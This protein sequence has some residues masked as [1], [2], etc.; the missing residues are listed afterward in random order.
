MLNVI[1][2]SILAFV[3]FAIG[4]SF[5][6]YQ[7]TRAHSDTPGINVATCT[8][9]PPGMV[10]WWPGEGN[11]NDIRGENNGVFVGTQSY[12]TGEVEHAFSFD[13]SYVEIPDSPSLSITGAISIDAWINPTTTAPVDQEILSKYDSPATQQSYSLGV[14]TG[15]SLRFAI[16]QTGDASILRYVDTASGTVSAGTF[17][18]VAATFDPATQ[19]MK[20]YVNGTDTLVSLGAGS[21]TVSSI[22]DSTTPVRIGAVVNSGNG[23]DL[24]IGLIDE[25]E[26]FSRALTQPEIQN[27]VTAGPLGKCRPR[28]TPPAPGMVS[29]WDGDDNPFDRQGTNHGSMPPGGAGFGTGKVGRA[30]TFDGSQN[31][32]AIPDDATLDTQTLTIDAWVFPTALDGA[33]DII[34]N[35]EAGTVQYEM[36]IKG[37]ISSGGSIPPGHLAVYV[38]GL[39]L[40]NDDGGWVDG[41][42][43]VP[44][45]TWSHVA[46][47]FDGSTLNA[48]INGVQ[49]RQVTGLSG[50]VPSTAGPFRIG[51]RNPNVAFQTDPFN[52]SI[53][54]VEFFNRALLDTEIQ[55]INNA[56]FA[57]KCK[58]CLAP[59]NN[60][61]GWWAGDGDARDVS[62]AGNDGSVEGALSF[63]I[64]KVGQSFRFNGTDAAVVAAP[65]SAS[66]MNQL[67]LTV[68]AWVRPALREGDTVDDFFPNNAV[69]NDMPGS[70]GHGFGVNVMPD[71]SEMTVEYQDGF[72]VIPDVSFN[73]DQWYHIA[74]VYTDGNV[75]SY[76]DGL[77]VDDFSDFDQGALDST[78]PV[79]IGKH[80]DDAETYGTRRFFKGLIDEVEIFNRA[81]DQKELQSLVA[82]GAS[83]KCKLG[84]STQVTQPNGAPPNIVK[85]GDATITF[86][87]GAGPG[88]AIYQTLPTYQAGPMNF[89]VSSPLE[90]L[91]IST[92]VG[93]QG[94]THICF[95]LQADEFAAAPFTQL[96]VF[97][98]EGN[99][100]VNRTSSSSSATRT[101]CA[102]VASFS[103]F[104]IAPDTN[105][106]TAAPAVISGQVTSPDGTPLAGVTMNLS[107]ASS[108]HT[109]TDSDG[110]YHFNNVNVDNFYTVAPS[111]VN[112]HFN[113]DSRSFSLLANK[114][115]AVFTA[116]PD[117]VIV[118]N[119]IDT[120]DYFVRQHYLDFLG[121]EPDEAGFNFWSDQLASCGSDADC[122]EVKRINVSAAYFLSIEFQQTGGLVD[123]LYRTSYGR[124]PLY[125]EFV[126]DTSRLAQNVVVGMGDWEHQLAANKQTFVADW[127]ERT[128]FKHAFDSL[129]NDAYIEALIANTGIAFSQDERVELVNSLA[130]G[131]LTRAGALLRIAED[132]R[133]V[134]AKRNEAFVMMEYF[135]YLRRDPDE[136]GYQFWLT[137]LNQ[138]GGNFEQAE[139]VKAFINSG[140][141]RQRFGR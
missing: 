46:M 6:S 130:N 62:G 120:P 9:P 75:K 80:N 44:L 36:S 61:I 86:P 71:G 126:P 141:Y 42:G 111:R 38:G 8:P 123:G 59:P 100:L 28:C 39:N 32:V 104:V 13:G 134:S 53:D 98:Q 12:P 72:R 85:V 138:F 113:P 33:E 90:V 3:A 43:A 58:L 118:G 21:T 35:K 102:D 140:E 116:V 29:W 128:A 127:V 81:L 30:F 22:F 112:Y 25:V 132:G 68:D 129:G 78:A 23:L 133:F 95:N 139:M 124:R 24:F 41:G 19:A 105:A 63:A 56:G 76:V 73:A 92:T 82:A 94:T 55:K 45:N 87:F 99:L 115:D 4:A 83:G 135:G 74:I 125:A 11:S 10:A 84:G 18:H 93:L 31:P 37:S 69:S 88:N 7:H 16:Y 1:R 15:G 70:S 106:P 67:P 60:M 26:L 89:G 17:T 119:T 97:H 49:T 121:R 27:I 14:R 108:A 114:T 117:A 122:L 20:I 52:G 57:G 109:I 79:S 50:T 65:A 77:L 107:G 91:D 96:R 66:V 103:Q 137:K 64:G 34:V 51:A 5:F 48:Y 136:S 131:T 110:N 40:P 2:V 47:T 101:L 54:E